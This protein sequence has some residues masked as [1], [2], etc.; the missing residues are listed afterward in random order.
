MHTNL[1]QMS[2]TQKATCQDVKG[3][4]KVG[5]L[6]IFLSNL[7]KTNRYNKSSNKCVTFSKHLAK[8]HLK[9]Q[10]AGCQA[11]IIMKNISGI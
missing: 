5:N 6:D 1:T 8:K 7:L 2:E 9:S 4:L 11:S 3:G 10:K